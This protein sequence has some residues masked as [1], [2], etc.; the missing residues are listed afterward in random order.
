MRCLSCWNLYN[1]YDLTECLYCDIGFTSSTYPPYRDCGAGNG[2]TVVIDQCRSSKDDW[3][4]KCYDGYLPSYDRL[5][6]EKASIS[7]C[8][9]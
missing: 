8:I 5:K 7:G 6:C 1:D 9:R 4:L 3:C 2:Y